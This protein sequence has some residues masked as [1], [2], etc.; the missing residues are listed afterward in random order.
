[1]APLLLIAAV[2]AAHAPA[3]VPPAV[4][5]AVERAL[6]APAARVEVAGFR[7]SLPPGCRPG[8]AEA[9]RPVTS[10]GEAPVR[11]RGAVDGVPCHGYGFAEVRV[12]ARVVVATR[13]V[14]AGDLLGP[15]TVPAEAELLPGRAPLAVLPAGARAARPVRAGAAVEASDLRSGPLPGEPLAVILRVGDVTV[16]QDGRALPCARGRTC[17]LLPGGRRVE[18]RLDGD[19]LLVE[20]P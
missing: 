10:S 18:G 17:A 9:L 19:R 6:V 12:F 5:T 1:M 14:Q 20:P 2:L 7:A 15:A 13:T 16:R 11:V 3:E 8:A 4:R